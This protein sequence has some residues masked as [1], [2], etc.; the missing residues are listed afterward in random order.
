MSSFTDGYNYIKDNS[1]SFFAAVQGERVGEYINNVETQVQHLV[2]HLNAFEGTGSLVDTLKGD[3]AE[4]WH[5]DTYNINAAINKSA[6]Q[7]EVPRSHGLGSVDIQSIVSDGEEKLK[8]SSKYY[9]T[10]QESAKQQ[11]KSVLEGTKGKYGSTTDPLYKGQFRLIP[12]DQFDKAQEFLDNRI[13]YLEKHRPEQ[14]ARY[15]DTLKQ[16]RDRIEDNDGN[17]SIPLTEKQARLLAKV[18]KEGKASDDIFEQIGAEETKLKAAMMKQA[19]QDICKAGL[20][21]ATISLVLKTTPEIIKAIDQ[22]IENGEIDKSQFETIGT[23]AISG[24][25]EGFLRGSI[26]ASIMAC[27]KHRGIDANAS[28]VGALT[29]IA[30]N[31]MKDAFAVSQGEKTRQELTNALIKEL[32]VSGW[33]IA[34]GIVTQHILAELPVFGYMLGSF[35]GSTIGSLTYDYG[36]K[37]AISFCVDSG[38][39]MFGLVEQNYTLPDSIMREIGLD[40]FD[41]ETFDVDSF[42]PDTFTIDSFQPESFNTDRLQITFLRRGVIGVSK[43]GYV[44]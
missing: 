17:Q 12:S 21:A 43:I 25:A 3:V 44:T 42:K 13:K 23:S 29:V 2:D 32:Y 37:K 14:V 4:F 6:H 30:V 16:L 36:Y 33:A 24:S 38:F 10:Y 5:A 1:A 20:T 22:L 40:V 31:T 34:G 41:Y 8:Y 28:V 19:A 15:K 39:T 9:K 26:A 35:L 11:A 7:M 18:A 27:L